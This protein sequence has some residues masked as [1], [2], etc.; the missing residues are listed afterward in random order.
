MVYKLSVCGYLFLGTKPED[1][2]VGGRGVLLGSW[3]FCPD[4]FPPPRFFWKKG[5][6]SGRR[7]PCLSPKLRPRLPLDIQV[8]QVGERVG[9]CILHYL[10]YDLLR[11]LLLVFFGCHRGGGGQGLRCGF[12]SPTGAAMKIFFEKNDWLRGLISCEH[13]FLSLR[14]LRCPRLSYSPY[15]R[16][17]HKV[18]IEL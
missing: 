13:R 8:L 2:A 7:G 16:L 6:G 5:L 4:S 9:N 18:H 12:L 14:L 15:S 10:P 11:C 3:S 1:L 17:T